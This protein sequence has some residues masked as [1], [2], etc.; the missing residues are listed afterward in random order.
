MKLVKLCGPLKHGPCLTMVVWPCLDDLLSG[1]LHMQC[2]AFMKLCAT[3]L[4]SSRGRSSMLN[5]S[6][7][8]S[9]MAIMMDDKRYKYNR[10]VYDEVV[11][12]ILRSFLYVAWSTYNRKTN[13]DILLKGSFHSRRTFTNTSSCERPASVGL[14]TYHGFQVAVVNLVT[15]V[16]CHVD[17]RQVVHVTVSPLCV[18]EIQRWTVDD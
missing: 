10:V 12:E 8:L 13:N 14:T 6:N 7:I 1:A 18:G 5:F 3:A 15:M 11:L 9:L 2:T 4:Q 16:T 17:G